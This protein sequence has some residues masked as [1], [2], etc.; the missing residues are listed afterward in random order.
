MRVKIN[1]SEQDWELLINSL[2]PLE[3]CKKVM[4]T[5]N[6][7]YRRILS[8]QSI[9]GKIKEVKKSI[10]KKSNS[11]VSVTIGKPFGNLKEVAEKFRKELIE[12]QTQPEKNTK[13]VLKS[14]DIKYDFQRIFYNYNG[15]YIVDFYLPDHGIVIEIDGGFHYEDSH[16]IK[17]KERTS[18]LKS[19]NNIKYLGRIP[20]KDTFNTV[21][22]ANKIKTILHYTMRN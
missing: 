1:M 13:A 22:L 14:L 3:D 17:D 4:E 12:K 10:P 11:P 16:L 9:P 18:L 19:H 15:F 2:R 6:C 7:A 8:T 20:N 21:G 5:I